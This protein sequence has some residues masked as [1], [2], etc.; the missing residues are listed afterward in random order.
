[1]FLKNYFLVAIM[2]VSAKKKII[3][4][5]EYH[6]YDFSFKEMISSIA[7]LCID[8][9]FWDTCIYILLFQKKIAPWLLL[10][11]N[12]FLQD[13]GWCYILSLFMLDENYFNLQ[14]VS[15]FYEY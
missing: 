14:A 12:G 1:M 5:L 13:I 2:T 4:Q 6:I 8:A 3:Q 7:C 15:F 10:F 11:Q 9:D